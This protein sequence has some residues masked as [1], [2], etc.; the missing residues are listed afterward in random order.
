ML[1]PAPMP[2]QCPHCHVVADVDPH[3][4]LGFSCRVCGGPRLAL[5]APNASL[6]APTVQLLEQAGREQTK[7]IIYTAAGLLLAA[8]GALALAV[9]TGV[10]LVA[11]P[12]AVAA[13]AAYVAAAVPGSSG[14]LALVLASR[15]RRQRASALRQ[16]RVRAAAE[17]QSQLGP[18][19]A[20]RAA[21]ILRLSPEEAELLLAEA[22]VASM[23]SELPPPRLRVEPSA[24]TLLS[25]PDDLAEATAPPPAAGRATRGDTEM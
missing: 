1:E 20:T 2:H 9:V 21:Q 10:V 24:A 8:T 15:A 5:D 11:E 6:G 4:A 22:S 12:G 14:V 3:A 17:L 13:L 23:L 16:A 25:T 19:D 7:H 18:L